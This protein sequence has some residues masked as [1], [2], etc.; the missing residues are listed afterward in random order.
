[1]QVASAPQSVAV[2]WSKPCYRMS[3]VLLLQRNLSWRV[4]RQ[5]QRSSWNRQQLDWTRDDGTCDRHRPRS[6]VN[7]LV[8]WTCEAS[9]GV[10][11]AGEGR[12]RG[13]GN[14]RP[15]SGHH[16]RQPLLWHDEPPTAT[17]AASPSAL[18]QSVISN[19]VISTLVISN[20][21]I[22]SSMFRIFE[23]VRFWQQTLSNFSLSTINFSL[24]C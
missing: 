14:R 4:K 19:H 1:M 11:Q 13:V 2:H 10:R 9:R 8:T 21:H 24:Y 23:S 15:R 22:T 7:R 17:T 18:Q 5:Q 6:D 3:S 16:Q 12:A 20:Q